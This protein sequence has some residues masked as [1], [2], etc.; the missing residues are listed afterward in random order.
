MSIVTNPDAEIDLHVKKA[1]VDLLYKNF[2]LYLIAESIAAICFVM[3]LWNAANHIELM[4]WLSLSLVLSG[5]FRHIL[6]FLYHYHDNHGK[7]HHINYWQNLFNA[8]ALLA[9]IIWGLG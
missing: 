9:A 6:T 4:I 8:G 5:F 3:Q 2:H 1:L 7:I